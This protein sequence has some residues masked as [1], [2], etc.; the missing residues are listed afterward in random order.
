M[1][2]GEDEE[3]CGG[4]G[5]WPAW[6]AEGREGQSAEAD[7]G[8]APGERSE[9]GGGAVV[10]SGEENRKSFLNMRERSRILPP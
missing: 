9:G 2:H 5:A 4:G 7:G 10:Q 6:R 1:R 8:A 3:E